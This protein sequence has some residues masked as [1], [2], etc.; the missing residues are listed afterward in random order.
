MMINSD[1]N[2]QKERVEQIINSYQGKK[3]RFPKVFFVWG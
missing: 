1:F 2:E 3:G